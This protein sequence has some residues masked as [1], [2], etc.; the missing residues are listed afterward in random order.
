MNAARFRNTIVLALNFGRD[1]LEAAGVI[2]YGIEGEDQWTRYRDRPVSFV[3]LLGDAQLDALY[4]L[5][6]AR[7][8]P[9]PLVEAIEMVRD[10][11]DD[12]KR[13]GLPIIPP[14]ARAKI[15]A[16]TL[17]QPIGA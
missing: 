14:A 5:V 6:A 16:S 13:D 11:D 2:A 4:A 8:K 10:A 17:S 9:D 3:L 7:Q 1:D 15:D 12:C